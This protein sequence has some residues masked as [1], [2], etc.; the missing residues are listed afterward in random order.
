VSESNYFII[1]HSAICI[2]SIRSQT[3]WQNRTLHVHRFAQFDKVIARRSKH[4]CYSAIT[5]NYIVYA[6]TPFGWQRSVGLV[7]SALALINVVN[8]H[9]ARLVLGWATVFGRVTISVCNN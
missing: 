1:H 6:V 9:R 4:V 7:V 8:R 2:D 3:H 5:Y